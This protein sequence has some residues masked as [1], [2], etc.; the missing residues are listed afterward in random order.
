MSEPRTFENFMQAVKDSC[1][2][3]AQRKGYTTG[4]VNDCNQLLVVTKTLGINNQHGV[5][6]ILYKCVE[7]LKEPREV[8]LIKV[9]GWAY[10][11]W[12]GFTD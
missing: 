12:K 5:A 2:T 8:L 9:A 3:H 11:L 10:I 1:E 4:G 7:Y 6:E